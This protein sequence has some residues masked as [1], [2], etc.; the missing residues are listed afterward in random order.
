MHAFQ[1]GST[2]LAPNLANLH[3]G[4]EKRI[5][6]APCCTRVIAQILIRIEGFGWTVT[7]HAADGEIMADRIDEIENGIGI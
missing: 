1:Y 7:L 4:M 3:G 5:N 6:A 2:A